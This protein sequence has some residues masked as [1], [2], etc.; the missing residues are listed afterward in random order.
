MIITYYAIKNKKMINTISR[1]GH[2]AS[3]PSKAGIDVA[4]R[5]PCPT[6]A[7]VSAWCLSQCRLC[8]WALAFMV[9][10]PWKRMLG[11]ILHSETKSCT[12]FHAF[13]CIT[14]NLASWSTITQLGEA[15]EAVWFHVFPDSFP[16]FCPS[17]RGHRT[18][19]STGF[20]WAELVL[21]LKTK[22]WT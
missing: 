20:Y 3:D 22:V 14:Y 16:R 17:G 1:G 5:Q 8:L 21:G 15:A 13:L 12:R 2:T 19:P 11:L 18:L 9:A 6:A 7:Q 10:F 4:E